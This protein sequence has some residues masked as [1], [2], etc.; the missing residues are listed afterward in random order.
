MGYFEKQEKESIIAHRRFGRMGQK[1]KLEYDADNDVFICEQGCVF[2][3]KM[4]ISMDI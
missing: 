2:E 4:W 1:T 3:L